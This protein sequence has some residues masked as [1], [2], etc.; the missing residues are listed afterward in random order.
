MYFLAR[1]FKSLPVFNRLV[2]QDPDFDE[3][4]DEDMLAAMGGAVGGSL[5]KGMTGLTITP[6]RPS[7][8]AEFAGPGPEVRLVDV[9]AELDH[10]GRHAIDGGAELGIRLGRERDDGQ[11]QHRERE[12]AHVRAHWE[13]DAESYRPAAG[14]GR[15]RLS[16]P[17]RRRG[18]AGRGTRPR[19]AR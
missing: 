6:L 8:K 14:P 7:G 18:G 12:Q 3:G 2:L 10:A 17:R 19:R 5:K 11:D 15:G 4:S 1:N 13:R 16:A 9:V